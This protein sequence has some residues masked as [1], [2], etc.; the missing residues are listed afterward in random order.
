MKIKSPR[1]KIRKSILI[2]TF[3]L[4]PGIFYYMSPYLVVEAA[5]EGVIVK[6]KPALH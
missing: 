5:L 4:F 3:I 1:Q 6:N 2:I